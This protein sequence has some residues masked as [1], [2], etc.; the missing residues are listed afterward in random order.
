MNDGVVLGL[1]PGSRTT[2]YAVMRTA[3]ELVDAGLLKADPRAAPLVRLVT[4]IGEVQRL[5]EETKPTVVVIEVPTAH[6]SRGRPGAGLTIYGMAVGAIFATVWCSD[7]GLSY[8]IRAYD[9]REWTHGVPKSE[10]QAMVATMVP[11]YRTATDPGGDV[12][13]AIGLCLHDFEW[14]RVAKLT[15]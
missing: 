8:K 5:L 10:R 6:V 14:E 12:A 4:M 13:D 3:D 11:E 2:G 9:E 1:D 7:F 15:E